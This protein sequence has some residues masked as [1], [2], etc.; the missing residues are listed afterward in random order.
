MEKN[1]IKEEM[2]RLG[3]KLKKPIKRRDKEQRGKINQKCSLGS[4]PH[5]SPLCLLTLPVKP[6]PGP[7]NL[8]T[9]S[10]DPLVKKARGKKGSNEVLRGETG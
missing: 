3:K 9:F 1:N 5:R 6:V 2:K 4:L 8:Y 10:R 7:S